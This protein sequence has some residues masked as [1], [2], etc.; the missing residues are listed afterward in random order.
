MFLD[1]DD[2]L[3]PTTDIFDRWGV[4]P[5][6]QYWDSL[7]LSD[8]Q[9]LEIEIWSTALAQFLATACSLSDRVVILTNSRRPWVTDCASRFCPEVLP[10]FER[11]DSALRVIY[12][13]EVL[14]KTKTNR[15]HPVMDD[16]HD[17]Y[18]ED[19]HDENQTAAKF[20]AMRGA[21]GEFYSQYPN[22][23]WKN[24][25][26]IGDMR[27]ERDA[28]QELTFTRSSPKRELIRTKVVLRETG[29]T[30]SHLALIL[31]I[32]NAMLPAYV[33]FDGDLDLDFTRAPEK[34]LQ[35]LAEQLRMPEILQ[36]LPVTLA[37]LL[38]RPVFE[39]A[40]SV[41]NP[42]VAAFVDELTVSVHSM[43]HD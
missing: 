29:G 37:P 40:V 9:Q 22:Q 36:A 21:A 33:H 28:L 8:E 6:K 35:H 38:G 43:I 4:P 1:W 25:L 16:S 15:A 39:K 7:R 23:S 41:Q 32:S 31:T 20:A 2:T 3:F 13:H 14:S 18:S 24:L 5:R 19:E 17:A 26:S 34:R 27:Y 11:E 42:D 30:V 12:A 10:L